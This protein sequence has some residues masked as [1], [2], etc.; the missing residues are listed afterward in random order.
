MR[1]EYHLALTDSYYL[2][3]VNSS[4][5]ES[6]TFTRVERAHT[7]SLTGIRDL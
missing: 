7:D 6:V 4:L 1:M 3:K 5:H 2:N